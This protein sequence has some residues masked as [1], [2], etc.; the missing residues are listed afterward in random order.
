M[1]LIVTNTAPLSKA[2]QIKGDF[3]E[4]VTEEWRDGAWRYVGPLLKAEQDDSE[5]PITQRVRF[6]H[7]ETEEDTHGFIHGSGDQGATVID[8]EGKTHKVEH[9]HYMHHQPVRADRKQLVQIA[10]EHLKLGP[11]AKLS[12]MAAAILLTAAGVKNVHT[13]NADAVRVQDGMAYIGKKRT[14][15]KHMVAMLGALG[16]GDGPLL[17]VDGEPVTEKDLTAYVIRFGQPRPR[18]LAKA[19]AGALSIAVSSAPQTSWNQGKYRC[20]FRVGPGGLSWL[21]VRGGEL[22]LPYH[23]IVRGVADAHRTATRMVKALRQGKVPWKGVY[24]ADGR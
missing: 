10:K 6:R 2:R 13:L 9:G 14:D 5:G 19:S 8:G 16:Q 22:A 1:R 4:T 15:D 21:T 12:V 24:R 7:P 17:Q 20:E 11:E 18:T 3:G 23:E